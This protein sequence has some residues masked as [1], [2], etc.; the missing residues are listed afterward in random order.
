MD[1]IKLLYGSPL[2]SVSTNGIKSPPFTLHR[3]TWQGCPLSPLLFALAVEPLAT[4]LRSENGFEGVSRYRQA[5]KISFYADDLLLYISNPASS[6]PIILDIFK[7]FGK[8]SGYKFNLEKS[9]YLLINSAADLLPH[10]LPPFRKATEG[11]KYLGIL[12]SESFFKLFQTARNFNPLL[13]R[14]VE[15]GPLSPSL[16]DRAG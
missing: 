1:W 6:L 2:A 5:H 11:L 13:N 12:V 3:G 10:G 7:K 16:F 14:W 15:G 8:C 9:D 4:W